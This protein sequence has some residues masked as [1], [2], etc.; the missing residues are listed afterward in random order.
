MT[1][2]RKK[3]YEEHKE[4]YRQTETCEICS[5]S[6]QIWN[7][8]QHKRTQKHQ[9]ALE[10]KKIKEEQVKLQQEL[11]ELKNKIKNLV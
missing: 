3:Y 6:F 11:D 9:K 4:D 1:E 2:Y 5:G 8:G 7:K 10:T